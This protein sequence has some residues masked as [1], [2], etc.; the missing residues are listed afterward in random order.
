MDLFTYVPIFIV[1]VFCAII[2]LSYSAVSNWK[3]LLTYSEYAEEY[4]DC[5]TKNGMKCCQ[6]GSR[7]IKNWGLNSANDHRRVFSC[8]HCGLKLYRTG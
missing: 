6:C 1:F 3:R 4:P 5:K 2:Y 7:S 8:N